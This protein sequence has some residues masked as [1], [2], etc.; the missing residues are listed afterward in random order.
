MFVLLAL[1]LET[2]DFAL[3]SSNVLKR[4]CDLK[5][6]FSFHKWERFIFK[7]H[8]CLNFSR[9]LSTFHFSKKWRLFKQ[10]FISLML[11]LSSTKCWAKLDF[12]FQSL[13]HE[14]VSSFKWIIVL[15]VFIKNIMT[16]AYFVYFQ[17]VFKFGIILFVYYVVN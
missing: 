17:S 4:S 2:A 13:G 15:H 8:I 10:L 11:W 1:V 7:S 9:V 14:F 3:W 16:S 6:S 12:Y 5:L